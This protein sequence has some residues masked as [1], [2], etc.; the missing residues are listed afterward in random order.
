ME[1]DHREC[2][3]V[4]QEEPEEVA[5]EVSELREAAPCVGEEVEPVKC[6]VQTQQGLVDPVLLFPS[7]ND[8]PSV[9]TCLVSSVFVGDDDLSTGDDPTG[10]VRHVGVFPFLLSLTP[11]VQ[12]LVH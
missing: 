4:P 3:G 9:V 12:G 1:D 11:Q 6:R 10:T 2:Q 5:R 7:L 8:G